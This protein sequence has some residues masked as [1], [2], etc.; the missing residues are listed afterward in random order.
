MTTQRPTSERARALWFDREVLDARI[1][2]LTAPSQETRPATRV[3]GVTVVL[4]TFDGATRV[5]GMLG[6]LAR[7]TLDPARYEV[8]VV[9]NGPSDGTGDVVARTCEAFPS[10]RVRVAHLPVA[11]VALARN[12]GVALAR[13]DHVTFVD[14]DDE[15]QPRFL[16]CLLRHA[17]PAT[18][19]AVP[20]VD[21]AEPGTEPV[22]G[23]LGERVVA[24]SGQQ[25]SADAHPWVLGYNAAKLVPTDIAERHAFDP[26]L[27]SGEDVA[28]WGSMLAEEGLAVRFVAEPDAAYVRLLRPESVSRRA[29]DFDFAV[30]QRV[31]V[32][33][34]LRALPLED[35]P[36]RARDALVHA[37]AQFVRR[38]C[39][40]SPGQRS[41]A[42]DLVERSRVVGFPW[43][44]L[45]GPQEKELVFAYCFAPYAD[46]SAIVAAK[47]VAS[48]R[49]RV[50]VISN[51]MSGVRRSDPRI[52]EMTARWVDRLE[53]VDTRP[54]FSDWGLI[55]E[56]AERSAGVAQ[57]WMQQGQRYEGMYSRALWAGSHVAAALTKL[58]HPDLR[59]AAEFSDPLRTDVHGQRRGGAV[60]DDAL[61]RRLRDVVD[62]VARGERLETLFDLVELSTFAL[63]DE[64]VFTNPNQLDYMLSQVASRRLRD[65]VARVAVVR[66]HPAPPP[67]MLDV[68]DAPYVTA[69]GQVHVG[70]F[71]SF[72]DNRGLD[73]VFVGLANSD[74]DVQRTIRLHVFSNHVDDVGARAA[75]LGV[76]GSVHSL[77][78]L[79]YADFL[80]ALRQFDV[81]LA[82]DV[83]RGAGL[84]VNPF[85]P[86]KVSD[87]LASGVP[88]W[89]LVDDG[90]PLS[91]MDL[92]YRTPVGDSNAAMR[93]LA[94]LASLGRRGTPPEA[95]LAGG[96][97]G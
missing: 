3:A 65:R 46:T 92:A 64:L 31:E 97:R 51:D 11:G 82:N 22:P 59:W 55:G 95:H 83:N 42:L 66:P 14:D 32:I 67:F 87:Y 6:S 45:Y 52:S 15:V 41:E 23:V 56:F 2:E 81:L 47:V 68:E 34:R 86:S 53:V 60:V 50:D 76:A 79:S 94:R 70:Y 69:E 28:Y 78:Y 33:T 57:Q 35:G 62:D 84:L 89:G 24:A 75:A 1:A 61:A 88:V 10:L 7:Q 26:S 8:V 36:A 44:T 63:A 85:L 12:L 40:A 16:E 30:R 93:T 20:V 39:E 54:A 71:G 58:R 25:V 18:I 90:S 37:Q 27:R 38:F 80:P 13:H 74:I 5:A 49:R 43:G 4:A 91:R 72:Y 96:S 17:A 9:P 29:L 19:V 77:P 73:E 21:R 48:R